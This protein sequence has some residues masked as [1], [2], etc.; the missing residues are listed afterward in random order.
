MSTRKGGER[1]RAPAHQNRV[2]FRHNKNSKKT[3]KIA[4]MP[5]YL[6]CQRCREKIEWKKKYRKY[7]PLT[8]PAKCVKCGNRTVKAA[9]HQL[10][11][12]CARL[13]R[14]CA[15]CMTPW[16]EPEPEPEE[17]SCSSCCSSDCDSY[18]DFEF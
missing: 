15:M 13:D 3:A 1:S 10:C 12:D 14:V 4:S 9:Y 11:D 16:N 18:D 8:V 17:S 7:K 2:A 5:I 6:V